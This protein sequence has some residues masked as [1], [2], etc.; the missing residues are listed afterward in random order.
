MVCVVDLFG[1]YVIYQCTRP[2]VMCHY[3]FIDLIVDFVGLK[4]RSRV[5]D[6]FFTPKE[7]Q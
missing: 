5:D 4:I 6:S 2:K 1:K 3:M 7:N